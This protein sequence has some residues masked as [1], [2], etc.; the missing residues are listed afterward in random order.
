M[1]EYIGNAAAAAYVGIGVSTWRSYGPRGYL[2]EPDRHEASKG[3]YLP[4]W[5]QDTLDAWQRSRP[6]RGRKRAAA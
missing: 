6:G 3:H 2:P 1:R 4:V 5:R